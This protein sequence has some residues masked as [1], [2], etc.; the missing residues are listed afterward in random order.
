MHPDGRASFKLEHLT[1]A[2]GIGHEGAHDALADVRA[3]IAV[4][5][6]IKTRQ[7]RLWDFCLRLRRKESVIEEM[8][9][10]QNQGLPF[11]HISGM[12]APERGCIA[13]AWP[14]APHPSNKN[15]VIVWDLASDPSELFELDAQ[16]IRTRMFTRTDELAEGVAR[17]PIKTIHLNKSP[18]VV[19]NL[20]TLSAASAAKWG[21]D[22]DQGLRHAELAAA[23]A[24]L[25]TGLWPAVFER[26][27]REGGVDVDEDLYGGFIGNADR[28]RLDHL[29]GL[30]PA[31]LARARAGFDDARLEELLFRYRARNF[32]DTLSPDEMQRWEAHRAARLLEGEGGAFNVDRYFA[33]IDAL[34]ETADERGEHILGAL[35]DY[36]E[37]IAPEVSAQ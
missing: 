34:S 25:L 22:V 32:P 36:A 3:T 21:I 23:K 24:H 35:Y 27:A 17:L 37:A 9:I 5:R 10:A 30:G 1:R 19:G 7:P 14:L 31:E 18:I 26:P 6:L 8:A 2:N 16:A 15:E 29:R 12:Y 33:Q 13:L 11:L 20:K 28:R 4:A